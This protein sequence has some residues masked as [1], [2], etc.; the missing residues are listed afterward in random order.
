MAY[1]A[2]SKS[3]AERLVG[4]TPTSA[5]RDTYLVRKE[6]TQA[7]SAYIKGQ[8]YRDGYND[9]MV[10]NPNRAP[11][12]HSFATMDNKVYWEEYDHGYADASN[13][14]ITD[15]RRDIQEMEKDIKQFLV[16]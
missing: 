16:D 11:R 6:G 14:I 8:G 1:T 12:G 7:M 3:A 5:I 4:S 13:R 15:A 2:D 9:R 10:G